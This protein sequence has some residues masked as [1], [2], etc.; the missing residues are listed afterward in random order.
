MSNLTIGKHKVN[1]DLYIERANRAKS[2][3]DSCTTPDKIS[4]EYYLAHLK[5]CYEHPTLGFLAKKDYLNYSGLTYPSQYVQNRS[6]IEDDD[7]IAHMK[8]R[9]KKRLAEL[10]PKTKYIREYITNNDR[11]SMYWVK[12]ADKYTFVDR[13]KIGLKKLFKRLLK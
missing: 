12:P 1:M 6:I 8:I 13:F 3:L 5:D 11:I 7:K 10:Y 4:V 9:L 2:Y